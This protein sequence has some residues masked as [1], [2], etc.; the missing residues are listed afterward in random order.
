MILNNE[1]WREK[2]NCKKIGPA[3]FFA[4]NEN[5][6]ESKKNDKLAKSICSKCNVR[7]ECL[8]YSLN[9]QISFGIWGGFSSRERNAIIKKL[10]LDNYSAIVKNIIN[11]P[12]K[13]KEKL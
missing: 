6:N 12:I 5:S 10:K 8:N 3:I 13:T 11:Q 7:P 2:A 4:D 9:Q 1:E